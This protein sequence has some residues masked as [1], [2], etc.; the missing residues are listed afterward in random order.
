MRHGAAALRVGL[1]E[2][3]DSATSSNLEC[4]C[5]PPCCSRCTGYRPILDAFKVFAKV[6]TGAYT[7]EAIQVG[8]GDALYKPSLLTHTQASS[9]ASTQSCN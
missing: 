2:G 4:S 7:E 8:S 9:Q 5:A 1:H 3:S 6:E